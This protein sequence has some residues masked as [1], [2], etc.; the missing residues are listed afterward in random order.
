MST[1]PDNDTKNE[2]SQ[3]KPNQE[4]PTSGVSRRNFISGSAGAIAGAGAIALGAA[5]S[6]NAAVSPPEPE[7]PDT[8]TRWKTKPGDLYNEK[9]GNS[10]RKVTGW[11]GNPQF[12][13]KTGRYNSS[14]VI[15]KGAY[16][17]AKITAQTENSLGNRSFFAPLCSPE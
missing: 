7:S 12:I 11:K 16:G 6:A 17:L 5:S 9:L 10:D 8:S 15:L 14:I 13:S 1:Q 3:E 2:N 4:Q